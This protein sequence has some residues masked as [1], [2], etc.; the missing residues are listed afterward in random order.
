MEATRQ[1]RR[2]L[3]W[4]VLARKPI[5]RREHG[6]AGGGNVVAEAEI[7]RMVF[8]LADEYDKSTLLIGT[9]IV[10]HLGLG[11]HA[12]VGCNIGIHLVNDLHNVGLDVLFLLSGHIL[13]HDF[14]PFCHSR[15]R[16]ICIKGGLPVFGKILKQNGRKAAQDGGTVR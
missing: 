1:N 8:A 10:I 4:G 16:M 12:A 15:H 14:L 6:G 9:G 5:L 3:G 7:I 11:D 2:A 13:V